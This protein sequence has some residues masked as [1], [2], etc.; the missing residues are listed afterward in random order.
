LLYAPPLGAVGV[1]AEL[2]LIQL[3]T[4]VVP[5]PEMVS[6][7]L[8]AHV[9]SPAVNVTLVT[10]AATLFDTVTADPASTV[11]ET[12]S[13]TLPAFALLIVVV[14]TIPLVCDGVITPLALMVV[15]ATG[16]GVVLP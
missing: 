10:F 14:P 3:W 15:A 12:N 5:L 6:A 13:P 7:T 16:S 8:P 1:V 2:V 4:F 9:Q 11:D